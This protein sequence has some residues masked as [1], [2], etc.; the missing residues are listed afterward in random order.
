MNHLPLLLAACLL[1]LCATAAAQQPQPSPVQIV[2]AEAVALFENGYNEKERGNHK[3]AMEAFKRAT[4]LKPDWAEAQLEL[5]LVYENLGEHKKAL[6]AIKEANRLKPNDLNIL[7]ELGHVLRSNQKF[8]D[9]VAVLKRV[10]AARPNEVET[11]Y[12]LGNTQLMAGKHEDAIK[13]LNQV[14]VLDPSHAEARE[15]LRVSSIRQNMPNLDHLRQQIADNPR[16]SAA[17]TDLG[18]AYNSMGM[19]SE[20]EVEYRKA[21]DLDPKNSD[22][23]IRFC[24]NYSEWGK[25]ELGIECYQEALKL[26][27][28]HV[29]FMSLGDLYQRQGK[30]EE[31]G[32]AYQKSIEL[33]STFTFSLYGLGYVLM[34]Q[35]KNEEAIEPLRRLLEVEP[36]NE[37]GNHALGFAYALT[38]NKTGAM[39]QY[40]ILQNLNARLAADLLRVIPQ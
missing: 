36:K 16:S 32:V 11:L 9:A 1:C 12:L 15:R 40:H 13:T 2:P 25:L 38:G 19:F 28:H 27:P 6:A 29:V 10:A 33:K 39:Q 8:G 35:G 30:F 20:A 18:Q 3:A 34:K 17:Y 24:V 21:V 23:R 5:A 31:A 4:E 7:L 22:A 37:F 14:L 26:K